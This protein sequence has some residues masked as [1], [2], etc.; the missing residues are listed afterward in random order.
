MLPMIKTA[1]QRTLSRMG[2]QVVRARTNFT[3]RE[4]EIIERVRSFTSSSAERITGL[5]N[6]VNY[7]AENRLDGAFVEC[8]VWRGGS[9]MVAMLALLERGDTSR[10]FHLFDTFEGMT[11]PTDRD[12]MFD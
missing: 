5:L 4:L 11:P 12:I 9:M 8:G 10:E 2:F 7:V 6:A 1:I 3:A